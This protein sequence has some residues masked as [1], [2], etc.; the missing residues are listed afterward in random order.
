MKH[1][2]SP[3]LGRHSWNC[4]YSINRH[5]E[6]T[7]CN[8]VPAA[9]SR[10]TFATTS[11]NRRLRHTLKA[12]WKRCMHK[13]HL[14][15]YAFL[16][17]SE[18]SKKVLRPVRH[19]SLP[20]GGGAGAAVNRLLGTVPCWRGCASVMPSM[21]RRMVHR[22]ILTNTC[23]YI[24]LVHRRQVQ[25]AAELPNATQEQ[26]HEPNQAGGQRYQAVMHLV[27][28]LACLSRSAG[29]R[30]LKYPHRQKTRKSR[31]GEPTQV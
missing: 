31:A 20:S 1:S 29:F 6:L 8:S 11:R 10:N 14:A 16:K 12:D 3:A 21:R 30:Y 19:P 17:L 27:T 2:A 25:R 26:L 4:T 18:P 7:A 13:T 15:R 9:Y 28:D 5:T 24:R 22:M 23:I